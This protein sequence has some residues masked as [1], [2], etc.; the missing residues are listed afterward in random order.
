MGNHELMRRSLDG[1]SVGDAFGERFFRPEEELLAALA[2]RRVPAR[3]PWTWTDDT[4][5]ALSLVETLERHG[6]VEPDA[7]AAGFAR[8]YAA[9][10]SRG[11]GG[12][13]H[14]VL[15][16][17]MLGTPWQTAARLLFDGE[18]S[19]GNGAAMRVA[20]LG[21]FFSGAPLS[22][23]VDEAHR[24]AAV[25]HAHPDGQ[26]GAVAVAVAAHQ[27]ANGEP[28]A[29]VW[30]QVLARTPPGPTRERLLK[31]SMLGFDVSS[32][33]A[34]RLLGSGQKVLSE[35]TVP[36]ALWCALKHHDDF[37]E[38]LWVTVAGRGDRDTTCAIVGGLVALQDAPP[39]AWL[40]AREPLPS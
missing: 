33:H 19:K 28:L 11:Y 9:E 34:A 15:A 17:L 29:L 14:E 32:E 16:A 21:A 30:T 24:S 2:E 3:P 20:P 18:G 8:R 1:L 36:F 12:G 13:A 39:E 35:D 27:L 31:P 7:L 37:E 23:V 25:T 38:A 40:R 26:A 4:A 6:T 10:P 22:T 5:M